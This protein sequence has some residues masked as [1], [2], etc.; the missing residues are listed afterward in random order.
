[1]EACMGGDIWTLLQ[2]HRCFNEN[3]ARF[4]T[5]CVVEG[6]EYLHTRGIV[7]R[8]LKPE[9]LML[10]DN[11]YVKLVDFGFAKKIGMTNK[12]WTF[13]GTPEYLAP[14]IIRNKGTLPEYILYLVRR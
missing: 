5:A 13:A 12:T 2:K 3:T 11:G 6:F 1:M 9:N 7:Y 8:D 10:A 14:E 4:M